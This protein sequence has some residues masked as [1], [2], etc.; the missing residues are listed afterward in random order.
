LLALEKGLRLN[1]NP[2][3]NRNV[4]ERY[5]KGAIESDIKLLRELIYELIDIE[6]ND[7]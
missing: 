6:E 5:I 7:A 3:D 2:P 4:Y 1:L